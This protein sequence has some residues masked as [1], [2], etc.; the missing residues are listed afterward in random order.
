MKNRTK[1]VAFRVTE[2]EHEALQVTA[3]VHN[4]KMSELLIAMTKPAIDEGLAAIEYHKKSEKAKAKR[5]AKKA[6][7]AAQAAEVPQ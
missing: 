7:K 2:E 4:V 6:E 5:A 3:L 1:V